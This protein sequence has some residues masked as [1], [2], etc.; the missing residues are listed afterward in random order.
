MKKH[1]ACLLFFITAPQHP[2]KES[3]SE[4]PRRSYSGPRTQNNLTRPGPEL[5]GL[6]RVRRP[7]RNQFSE[8]VA[9]LAAH[10]QAL[11][12]VINFANNRLN[13]S[14]LRPRVLSEF[15]Q[16]LGVQAPHLSLSTAQGLLAETGGLH[17]E[18]QRAPRINA[19]VDTTPRNNGAW[20][21]KAEKYPPSMICSI[22]L[23]PFRDPV[24]AEDGHSYERAAIERWLSSGNC[25]SPKTGARMGTLLRPNH[26]M[27]TAVEELTATFSPDNTTP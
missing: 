17:A 1:I 23:E 3:M 7:A 26:T 16:L 12:R 4:R 11:D 25:T 14:G 15:E 27:R 22:L 24:Q 21:E 20:R 2:R 8:A 10:G 13:A 5:H 9:A 18:S 19:S 6:H